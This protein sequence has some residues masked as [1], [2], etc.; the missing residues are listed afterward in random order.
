MTVV[1]GGAVGDRHLLYVVHFVHHSLLQQDRATALHVVHEGITPA[2]LEAVK[3][4]N[5]DRISVC[6]PLVT[7]HLER[8]SGLSS[9]PHRE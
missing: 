1:A 5:P 7:K 8:S 2:I 6:F 4:A 9:A 3:P